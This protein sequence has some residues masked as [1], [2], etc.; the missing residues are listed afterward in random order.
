MLAAVDAGISNVDFHL[1]T[2]REGVAKA[3]ESVGRKS[4]F[5]V[6]K[7]NK[8]PADMTDPHAAAELVRSTMKTE[9]AA[10]GTH[11]DVL[12]L[13]DS[14]SCKVMQ[15]QWAVLE[16]MLAA[17]QVR[18][19]G[20]YNFCR[21][22]IDCLLE[23]AKHPPAVNYLMR[24]VGMGPDATGVIE[25]GEKKKGIRTVAYGVLGEPIALPQLL[26][27]G[28]IGKIA[29]AHSRSVEEVALMWNVQSGYAISN[30]I[31]ADYG[32][33]N[34][35]VDGATSFCTDG[36]AAAIRAMADAS[37]WSLTEKEMAQLD[38]IRLDDY[39][40]SPTYYSSAGCPASFG[41]SEHPTVSACAGGKGSVWC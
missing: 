32:P 40:Q 37:S 10:L 13:K 2:E 16:E 4:L 29:A 41:V 39:P 38:D 15:A 35:K 9:L 30:R 6:T 20:T 25:Y 33:A 31:T 5:L 26:T 11:L 12:L 18:A 24:H 36:C 22:A 34:A 17:G 23:T 19:L 3:L 7:L 14:A 1:G 8:P 21:S 27:D 28:T